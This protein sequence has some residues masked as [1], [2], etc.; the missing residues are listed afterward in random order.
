M[1]IQVRN[2][3]KTVLEAHPQVLNIALSQR[4]KF[5]GWLKMELAAIAETE[6]AIGLQLEAP[7]CGSKNFNRADIAFQIDN[8]RYV[9][10]LKTP[11]TNWRLT[12]VN[13]KT[14][15][16][17]KNIQSIIDDIDK[18][19][20]CE[21]VGIVAFTLFPVPFGD[22]RWEE[23][24]ERISNKTGITISTTDC[25]TTVGVPLANGNKG[26]ILICCFPV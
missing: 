9:L 12:G 6:G 7:I 26:E 20:D 5:E 13:S 2:W 1:H 25:C 3:I 16:V 8:L 22:R 21:D 23:Y 24:I 14:R 17:T 19:R 10:E 4:A 18:L 15:P 11:N